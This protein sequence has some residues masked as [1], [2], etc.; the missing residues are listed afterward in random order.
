MNNLYI[1]SYFGNRFSTH[2]LDLLNIEAIR[3]TGYKV[4]LEDFYTRLHRPTYFSLKRNVIQ[5]VPLILNC[6]KIIYVYISIVGRLRSQGNSRLADVAETK[7]QT[8]LQDISRK[9]S[10]VRQA[11]VSQAKTFDI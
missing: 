10:V 11:K 5:L 4:W 8:S 7:S 2:N 1:A 3:S 6:P 9:H